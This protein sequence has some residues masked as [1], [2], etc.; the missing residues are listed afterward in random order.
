MKQKPQESICFSQTPFVSKNV[1]KNQK[2]IGIVVSS[3]NNLMWLVFDQ[4]WCIAFDATGIKA[5]EKAMT[6][7]FKQREEYP[8]ELRPINMN[9]PEDAPQIF[10]EE[11][12]M[13]MSSS[14]S[15]KLVAVFTTHHHLDHSKGNAYW[16][17][18]NIIVVNQSILFE[19]LQKKTTFYEKGGHFLNFKML[20]F[21][22]KDKKDAKKDPYDID[23]DN[24]QKAKS[25]GY[26]AV[27]TLKMRI[28]NF[29]VLCIETPCHTADSQCFQVNGKWLMTGDTIFYLGCGRFF[30]GSPS[31]MENSFERLGCTTLDSLYCC[32]GHD[33]SAKDHLFAKNYL[34]ER[35]SHLEGRK[36]LT[37]GE[38]KEFN[39]FMNVEDY[40]LTLGDI[41]V[42][43]NTF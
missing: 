23:S 13:K 31:E 35:I 2:C 7:K 10:T 41:R 6:V 8:S 37:W 33:Y 36:L 42:L 9:D 4:L 29:E 14:T 15:R 40:G 17:R 38:E 26:V 32:Y 20:G 19:Q 39:P 22:Y 21:C 12:I 11:Q 16:K 27:G 28:K 18:K 34:G 43:K 24:N 1:D 25:P 5:L 30:E 3:D